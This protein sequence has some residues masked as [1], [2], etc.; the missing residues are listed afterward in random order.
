MNKNIIV[1]ATLALV[2]ALTPNAY[3]AFNLNINISNPAS[4]TPSQLQTLEDALDS[5]EATW[6]SAI[7]GYRP[8]INISGMSITVSAGSTFA[9]ALVL[10]SVNQGGFR[11]STSARIRINPGTIDIFGSWDGSGPTPPNTEFLGVNYIDELMVHEIGHA[12]GL[13]TQWVS[14]GVYING[15]GQYTGEFGL[16]AYQADFDSSA[17]FVPVELAGSSGTQNAHWDQ[18]MRSSSQEGNPGDPWSLDPRVG[19]LDPL[20]RDLGLEVLTGAIDPD[21]GEPFLSRMTV[22]S[23]R[24]IGFTVVPEPTSATMAI[25]TLLVS[26]TFVR[27][28]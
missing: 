6:E 4:F 18:L 22:Q 25:I 23:L 24:D 7:T 16:A 11:L 19:I 2:V 1:V 3:A 28:R 9:D 27:K 17:T 13:G 21:Y 10:S 5:A 14:N 15:T 12:L 26:C 8:G 20:G